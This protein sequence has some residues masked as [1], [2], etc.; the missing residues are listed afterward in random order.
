MTSFNPLQIPTKGEIKNILSGLRF[1]AQSVAFTGIDV[2]DIS[3][4]LAGFGVPVYALCSSSWQK[5]DL[6]IKMSRISTGV[7]ERFLHESP[8]FD[9]ADRT[10]G[11]ERLESRA[12]YFTQRGIIKNIKDNLE[13]LRPVTLDEYFDVG[14]VQFNKAYISPEWSDNLLAKNLMRKMALHS[15]IYLDS[16]FSWP[17]SYIH[18]FGESNK[19]TALAHKYKR[20][21]TGSIVME[22]KYD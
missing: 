5:D 20:S 12:E 7:F 16:P 22:K 9:S 15:F 19:Q 1:N 13:N 10:L 4:A 17:L 18:G 3:L 21:T 8:R 11:K 2:H 14:S 6:K